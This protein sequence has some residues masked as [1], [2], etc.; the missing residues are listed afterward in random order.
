MKMIKGCI[1][2]FLVILLSA[3]CALFVLPRAFGIQLYSIV[4]GSMVPA[5]HLNDL[6]YTVPT[7]CGEISAGD[8]I[9]FLLPGANSIVTHRVVKNDVA[10]RQIF[11][12]GDANDVADAAPVPYQNVKGVVRFHI[13]K[14]GAALM[15][16]SSSLGRIIT[17]TVGASIVLISMILAVGAEGEAQL[18][19]GKSQRRRRR[20]KPD[21]G[22]AP[23][24]RGNAPSPQRTVPELALEPGGWSACEPASKRPKESSFGAGAT[25][26]GERTRWKG[27][28][29]APVP[30]ANR[31]PRAKGELPPSWR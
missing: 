3:A 19:R 24:E 18:E 31:H 20:S 6:I 14:I 15:A 22:E 29:A 2:T 9:S 7:D 27:E 25:K 13:P 16:L 10:E 4:S 5:Y 8:T 30:P 17:L 12:K 23:R 26:E 21:S 28:Q 11:T 1:G